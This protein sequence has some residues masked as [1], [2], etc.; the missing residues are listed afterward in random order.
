MMRGC[1]VKTYIDGVKRRFKAPAATYGMR[2][3]YVLLIY[4]RNTDER[5]NKR[6]SP[7]TTR[8]FYV[9]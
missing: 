9:I 3:E 4:L 1:A 8:A 7:N 5:N 2:I 6:G